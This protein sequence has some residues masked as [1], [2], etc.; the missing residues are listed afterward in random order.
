[1]LVNE[2]VELTTQFLGLVR[3][4][5]VCFTLSQRM[6]PNQNSRPIRQMAE[7]MRELSSESNAPQ[8]AA[9]P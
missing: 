4:E 1:M 3:Q 7:L 5:K 2:R 9:S 6:L 8:G